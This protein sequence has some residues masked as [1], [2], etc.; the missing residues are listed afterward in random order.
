MSLSACYGAISILVLIGY[1]IE[2]GQIA[3][4]IIIL[5]LKINLLTESN[6]NKKSKIAFIVLGA[7]LPLIKN[8]IDDCNSFL[9]QPNENDKKILNLLENIRESAGEK[10]LTANSLLN[11]TFL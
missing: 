5:S 10:L 7:L 4:A 9:Q 2:M 1:K 11:E 3:E 8:L 6:D